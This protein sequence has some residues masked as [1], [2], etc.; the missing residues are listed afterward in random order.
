MD[1]HQVT[2]SESCRESCRPHVLSIFGQNFSEVLT[3]WVKSEILVNGTQ[4][5]DSVQ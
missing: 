3:S 2:P 4:A 1:V 5:W